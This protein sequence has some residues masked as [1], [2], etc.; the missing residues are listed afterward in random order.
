MR[1][2]TGKLEDCENPAYRSLAYI[3]TKDIFVQQQLDHD[4]PHIDNLNLSQK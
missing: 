2:C 1:F 4:C 3:A